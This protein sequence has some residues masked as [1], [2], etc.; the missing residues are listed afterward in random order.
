[1]ILISPIRRKGSS[2]R[3]SIGSHERMRPLC[4]DSGYALTVRLCLCSFS[5]K[6]L[7]RR[8]LAMRSQASV[9][10][11]DSDSLRLDDDQVV[12]GQK[13]VATPFAIASQKRNSPSESAGCLFDNEDFFA[14]GPI[15]DITRQDPATETE[16]GRI[17]KSHVPQDVSRRQGQTP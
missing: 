6:H 7:D 17:L 15:G 8:A 5:S 12:A 13:E 2:R 1:M 4:R 16:R 9:W 3:T 11:V 10:T 14:C